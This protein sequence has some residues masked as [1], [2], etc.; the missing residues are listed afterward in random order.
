MFEEVLS[1]GA[2]DVLESLSPHLATFYMAGG[3]GLAL[4]LGHRRSDDF[5]FF[6]GT[7]FNTDALLSLISHDKV[8]FTSLGTVHCEIKGIRVSFLYYDVP[9]IS[10]A[11]SWH[12]I[13][14]AHCNDIVAEKIK[15]ISQ[16]GS[17]KDF[18]DLYA[19]LKMKYSVPEVCDLFKRRFKTSEINFYHVV[20]SLIFFEDAEQ[21]PRPSMLVSGDEWEWEHIKSFFMDNIK[22]FEHELGL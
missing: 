18:I 11:L 21:E 19:V 6:S 15:T 1:E 20:K 17:K 16:R 4:Q 3:T 13:K 10:P 8:L 2:I 22:L 12:G 7:L 9:L 5:D 14:L